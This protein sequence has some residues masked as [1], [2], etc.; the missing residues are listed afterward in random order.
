MTTITGKLQLKP[1]GRRVLACFRDCWV[2]VTN[3]L[4]EIAPKRY[5]RD[6]YPPFGDVPAL[7]PFGM[8]KKPSPVPITA[9]VLAGVWNTLLAGNYTL[10]NIGDAIEQAQDDYNLSVGIFPNIDQVGITYHKLRRLVSVYKSLYSEI[11]TADLR[12]ISIANQYIPPIQGYEALSL[13][14]IDIEGIEAKANAYLLHQEQVSMSID[15]VLPPVTDY[16][17]AQ[18]LEGTK[19]ELITC[20]AEN[21][22][23]KSEL[24]RLKQAPAEASKREELESNKKELSKANERIAELEQELAGLHAKKNDNARFWGLLCRDATNEPTYQRV[25]ELTTIVERAKAIKLLDTDKCGRLIF[26]YKPKSGFPTIANCYR[27]VEKLQERF[28]L[29]HDYKA[30]IV[31]ELIGGLSVTQLEYAKHT[32]KTKG[33]KPRNNEL[34]DSLFVFS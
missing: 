8:V 25:L 32:Y 23:L 14:S 16:G 31:S 9:E 30:R 19:S 7:N 17:A 26:K 20:R 6:I 4:Y 12:S 13:D 33:S 22:A 3:Y 34:I 2:V 29:G 11:V 15:D 5:I 24:E 27:F 18:E 10:K 1:E 21:Q 28:Q